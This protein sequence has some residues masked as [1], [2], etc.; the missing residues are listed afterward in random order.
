MTRVFRCANSNNRKRTWEAT[1]RKTSAGK[2][3]KSPSALNSSFKQT[4][5]HK[6]KKQMKESKQ[7]KSLRKESRNHKRKIR[8]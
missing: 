2:N 8:K 5:G 7:A 3:K 1:E 4:S 6:L